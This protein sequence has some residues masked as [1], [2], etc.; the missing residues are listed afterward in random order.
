MGG[1]FIL[2]FLLG[3]SHALDADHML[4]LTSLANAKDSK[5]LSLSKGVVWGIGH[6]VMLLLVAITVIMFGFTIGDRTA[7]Y[8]E[9]AVGVML[10]GLGLNVLYRFQK[11]KIHAHVHQHSGEVHVHFHAHR[12]PLS[13]KPPPPHQTID[14]AHAHFNRPLLTSFIIGL[15]HGLAGSAALLVLVVSSIHSGVLGFLYVAVF[16]AGSILGMAILSVAI[17]IPFSSLA[18]QSSV[19][20]ASLQIATFSASICFG[21]YI[22]Y[23]RLP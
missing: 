15:V 13:P 10:I 4:A 9:M 12:S 16:G 2:G 14:H 17:S 22:I 8:L 6:S 20:Y 21:G 19:I 18:K 11:N 23:Q 1:F 3:M 5:K 7:A